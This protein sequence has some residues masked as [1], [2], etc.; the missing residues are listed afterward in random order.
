VLD[1]VWS[2]VDHISIQYSKRMDEDAFLV[3]RQA[4]S[5]FNAAAQAVEEGGT[6]IVNTGEVNLLADVVMPNAACTI[7]SPEGNCLR[8]PRRS[9]LC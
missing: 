3:G 1:G 9:R 5:S 6:I 7:T 4:F 2:E 8:S